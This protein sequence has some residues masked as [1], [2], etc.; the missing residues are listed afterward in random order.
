MS[1]ASF[2]ALYLAYHMSKS[3][4]GSSWAVWKRDKAEMECWHIRS[5]VTRLVCGGLN[6]TRAS[7]LSPRFGWV[8]IGNGWRCSHWRLLPPSLL[9]KCPSVTQLSRP[10]PVPVHSLFLHT[11][12]FPYIIASVSKSVVSPGFSDCPRRILNVIIA[13]GC[14]MSVMYYRLPLLTARWFSGGD[15]GL[16]P[17]GSGWAGLS[18][19]RLGWALQPLHLAFLSHKHHLHCSILLNGLY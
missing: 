12:A 5:V 6:L 3:Y 15:D 10:P 18:W 17:D 11:D 1:M 16:V 4:C 2:S 13:K 8:H 9:V 14:H 19:S 7:S